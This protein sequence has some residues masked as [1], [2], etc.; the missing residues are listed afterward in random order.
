M[1]PTYS[2]PILQNLSCSNRP[3]GSGQKEDSKA[4]KWKPN[5]ASFISHVLLP[6]GFPIIITFFFVSILLKVTLKNL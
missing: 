3:P 1:A 2:D 6:I 5:F 4:K